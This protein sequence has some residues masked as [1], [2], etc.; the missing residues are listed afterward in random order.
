M[1]QFPDT[2]TFTGTEGQFPGLIYSLSEASGSVPEETT[3]L[4]GQAVFK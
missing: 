1:S 3:H 4:T 2:H